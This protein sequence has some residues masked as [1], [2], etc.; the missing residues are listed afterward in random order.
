[1]TVVADYTYC[2]SSGSTTS[3][4]YDVDFIDI[5]TGSPDGWFWDFGDGY[6]SD[7]QHPLHTYDT[8]GPHTC[9]LTVIETTGFTTTLNQ[10]A[11]SSRRWKN[12]SPGSG[13]YA[14][15]YADFLAASWATDAANFNSTYILAKN[16]VFIY[17]AYESS[18]NYNLSPYPSSSNIATLEARTINVTS[19]NID[20]VVE[21]L[22]FGQFM[23]A[24]TP[25]NTY[26]FFAD[27]SSH[28]GGTTGLFR[29]QDKNLAAIS[30]VPTSGQTSGWVLETRVIIQPFATKDSESKTIL[31]LANA[32]NFSANPVSGANPLT[33]TFTNLSPITHTTRSW[34]RRVNG[35]GAAFGE[36]STAAAPPEIF[37][38]T[39]P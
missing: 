16:G 26:V 6:S 29:I 36:F 24:P 7:V 31:D 9:T 37:D 14:G 1:M 32:I 33:S 22:E 19:A 30:P 28:L 3:P 8:A 39:A 12:S 13:D 2:I 15:E 35:S 18:F 38:K 17:T 10:P 20:G 21:L 23:N 11:T 4:P 34:R 27:F 25:L 5:S